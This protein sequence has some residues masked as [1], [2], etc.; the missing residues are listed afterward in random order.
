MGTDW[1]LVIRPKVLANAT[2]YKVICPH[3]A[4]GAI[5]VVNVSKAIV[6]AQGKGTLSRCREGNYDNCKNI[7]M[8]G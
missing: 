7:D 1:D 8:R 3:S 4:T 5:P 2:V 6:R